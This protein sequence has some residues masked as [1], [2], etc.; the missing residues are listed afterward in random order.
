MNDRN[1]RGC[2]EKSLIKLLLNL[3]L[4]RNFDLYFIFFLLFPISQGRSHSPKERSIGLRNKRARPLKSTP[5]APT[6][7]PLR[8]L[9]RDRLTIRGH[10]GR[11]ASP[12]AG[13]DVARHVAPTPC[14]LSGNCKEVSFLSVTTDGDVGSY[15][16][17]QRYACFRLVD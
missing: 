4:T 13:A 11:M 3:F 7:P 2:N 14:G 15:P 6:R 1:R 17:Y 8:E 9:A 12:S 5:P 10:L 16:V